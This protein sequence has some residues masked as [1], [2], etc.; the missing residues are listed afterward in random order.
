MGL[1]MG[2]R[3]ALLRGER[4]RPPVKRAV[5]RGAAVRGL[6][7][8]GGSRLTRTWGEN[9]TLDQPEDVALHP[10][11]LLV[12]LLRHLL[13]CGRPVLGC[14]AEAVLPPL[15]CRRLLSDVL[16]GGVR[17]R[18]RT[19]EAGVQSCYVSVSVQQNGIS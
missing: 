3:K 17:C 2:V 5:S 9:V 13:L 19:R 18:E 14:S 6:G 8:Q 1:K 15:H 11:S 4:G 7:A 16:Q 10:Q 12:L